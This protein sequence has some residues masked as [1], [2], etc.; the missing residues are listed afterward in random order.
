MAELEAETANPAFWHKRE[1]AEAKL[2]KIKKLKSKYEPW[3][4]LVQNLS[5]LTELYQLACGE[6]DE[7]LAPEIAALYHQLLDNFTRQE[8]AGLMREESDMLD[9][10][11]TIH[12]GAG[13]LES[14]DWVGMLYRMYLRYTEK[15]GFAVT[16]LD[17]QAI[18][19]GGFKSVSL[20][21]TGSFAYG[22]LK[23]ETG[24]HRMVRIS[25][26]DTNARRHTTFAAVYVSPVLDDTI[27]LDIKA[28]ELRIDTYRAGGAGGQKVNKTDSAVRITHLPTGIVVQ[29]QNERSQHQNKSVALAMLKGRLYDYYKAERDNERAANSAEKKEIGW[30]NQ[31]RSY[32]F[33][34]Y[35]MV[36]D[37]RTKAET[38]NVQ[39]VM[40]GELD[41]FIEALL[42][43]GNH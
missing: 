29:C 23:G 35:T 16:I 17:E 33:N 24:V 7:S 22:L 9:C 34:P 2:S 41:M 43:A 15:K 30:G 13:G 4:A 20:Q 21:I 27:N 14:N 31:V 6:A 28:D 40:D 18:D 42:R 10:F 39:A 26:F 37:S 12:A 8:T 38:G 11:L 5:D 1:E 19:E 25:P 3:L 36:K 32:V